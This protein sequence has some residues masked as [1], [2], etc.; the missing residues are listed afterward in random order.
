MKTIQYFSD[1]YL[2]HCK[3]LS[4]DQIATFLESFRLMHAPTDKSK[5][6]SLKIPESLLTAFRS[7]CET[8]QLKYQ[9]QI[10]TLMRAWVCR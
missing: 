10:K 1:E 3:T 4:P 6:I 5:L 9:T 8:S 7:K 2:D